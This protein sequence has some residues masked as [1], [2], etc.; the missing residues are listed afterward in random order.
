VFH[1]DGLVEHRGRDIDDG[2]RAA[3]RSAGRVGTA[4]LPVVCDALMDC[5]PDSE[6]DVAVLGVR[7]TPVPGA[8]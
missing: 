7:L 3:E 8:G 2:M 6:D 4:P 1:T 5:C